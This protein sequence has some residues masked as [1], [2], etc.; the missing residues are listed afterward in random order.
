MQAALE[1]SENGEK[2]LQGF[3]SDILTEALSDIIT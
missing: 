3:I 1:T 2:A